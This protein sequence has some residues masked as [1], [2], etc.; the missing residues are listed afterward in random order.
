MP[1]LNELLHVLYLQFFDRYDGVNLAKLPF[2]PPSLI[3]KLSQRNLKSPAVDDCA[4]VS[5]PLI[6]R[7][8]HLP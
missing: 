2:E 3:R 8:Q 6:L 7:R 1:F 4:F 5:P